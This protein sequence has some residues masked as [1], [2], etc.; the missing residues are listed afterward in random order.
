MDLTDLAV[1][2]IPCPRCEALPR[3]RCTTISGRPATHP[4]SSRTDPVY[5]AWRMGYAE[6]GRDGID[7]ARRLVQA[8]APAIVAI[9][10][11]MLDKVGAYFDR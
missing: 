3:A 10:A 1:A 8:E 4:H 2:L 11:P 6:G 5:R 9:A 7:Q